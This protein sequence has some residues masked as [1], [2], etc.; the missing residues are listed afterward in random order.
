MDI[1]GVGNYSHG[2]FLS[3][4]AT[5]CTSPALRNHDHRHEF[6]RYEM[7]L[8]SSRWILPMFARAPLY[9]RE[10]NVSQCFETLVVGH[11]LGASFFVVYVALHI[12]KFGCS[13]R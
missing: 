6:Y 4:S 7:K 10:L 8:P 11:V 13:V 12:R 5:S 2:R 9:V 1:L 3:M